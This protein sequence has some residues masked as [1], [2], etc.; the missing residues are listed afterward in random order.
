MFYLEY[1][2]FSGEPCKVGVAVTDQATGLYAYGAIMAALLH[3]SKTGRGQYI[4]CNLLS[5]QVGLGTY[6]FFILNIEMTA[7]HQVG[8]YQ[9]KYNI[10]RCITK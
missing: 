1:S 4:D 8:D 3:R 2:I 10:W 5:T 7:E 9:T 6:V